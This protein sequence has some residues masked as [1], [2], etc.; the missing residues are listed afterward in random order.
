MIEVEQHVG[1]LVAP[2]HEHVVDLG[3]EAGRLEHPAQVTHL[4]PD[5]RVR[6]VL[7]VEVVVLDIGEDGARQAELGVERRPVLVGVEQLAVLADDPV[8]LLV[9]CRNGP[10]EAL[11]LLDL[12]DVVGDVAEGHLGVLDPDLVGV[13]ETRPG[14]EVEPR[15]GGLLPLG[16]PG[17]AGLV[18]LELRPD[19]VGRAAG[20]EAVFDAAAHGQPGELLQ[21]VVGPEQVDVDAGDHLGDREVG[22]RR[23]RGL[24]EPEEVQVGRVAEVEE[25][26][27]VLPQG[28]RVVQEA[29][30]SGQQRV[31]GAAAG[32]GGD[33]LEVLQDRQWVELELGHL[34]HQVA[35]LDQPLVVEVVPVLEVEAGSLHEDRNAALDLLL[36]GGYG[37]E[38]QVAVEDPEVHAVRRRN[39][40]M[41]GVVLPQRRESELGQPAVPRRQRF[42]PVDPVVEPEAAVLV[43]APFLAEQRRVGVELLP[44]LR[45]LGCGDFEW[46]GESI[47]H[48]DL[49]RSG[50]AGGGSVMCAARCAGGP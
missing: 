33:D 26:E 16:D 7:D 11:T 19:H 29:V 44:A 38:E 27:V 4:A 8:A 30:V 10:V 39:L 48:G 40:E 22:D 24:A 2:E 14:R 18:G 34:L 12:V 5:H 6:P 45:P 3:D 23:E 49:L 20:R 13:V 32:S 25:L 28:H 9:Q 15:L 37:A 35:D 1:E 42:G 46:A 21:L 31:A 36:R 50:G 43:V 47:G 41:A 17:L